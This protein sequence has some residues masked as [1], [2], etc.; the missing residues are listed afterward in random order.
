M[1]LT[2]FSLN[3]STVA[4]LSL[5]APLIFIFSPFL[6]YWL[7]KMYHKYGHPCRILLQSD[8]NF[9]PKETSWFEMTQ[10]T[11][12]LYFSQFWTLIEKDVGVSINKTGNIFKS[13]WSEKQNLLTTAV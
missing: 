5:G 3:A 8:T 13:D 12:D 7:F 1:E 4:L 6:Q 10:T 2:V 11:P 9:F